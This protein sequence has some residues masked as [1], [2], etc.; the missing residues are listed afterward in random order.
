MDAEL[1]TALRASDQWLK[2]LI[3]E[4]DID[5]TDTRINVNAVSK[6]DGA[7]RLLASVTLQEQLRRNAEVLA[8]AIDA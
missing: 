4:N 7:Q 1:L 5:P 6:I 2:L 8:K 3:E